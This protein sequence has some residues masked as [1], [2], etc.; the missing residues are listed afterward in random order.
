LDPPATA[1]LTAV[2]MAAFAANALLCHMALGSIPS[3]PP[4]SQFRGATRA[5]RGATTAD[6]A[7]W[8]ERFGTAEHNAFRPYYP[9]L[10]SI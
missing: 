8:D 4:T 7:L 3:T 2:A 5:E 1:L 6:S 9:Y 10:V